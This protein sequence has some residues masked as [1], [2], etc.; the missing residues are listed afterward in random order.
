[1]NPLAGGGVALAISDALELAQALL[2]RKVSFASSLSLTVNSAIQEYKGLMF[3][4]AKEAM[5]R[6]KMTLETYFGSDGVDKVVNALQVERALLDA[7]T[8]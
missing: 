2:K 6:A 4:R 7:A 1:M 3:P 8:V 5:E